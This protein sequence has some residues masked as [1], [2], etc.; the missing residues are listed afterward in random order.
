MDMRDRLLAAETGLVL[1]DMLA[2]VRAMDADDRIDLIIDG[3]LHRQ[4][5]RRMSESSDAISAALDWRRFADQ[6]VTFAE[7]Q[8]R[9]G[10]VA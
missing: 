7:L 10:V 1:A 6:H 4:C 3:F 9:R 8:R 5:R 2:E